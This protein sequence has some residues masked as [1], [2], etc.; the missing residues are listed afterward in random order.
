MKR[1]NIYY[2]FSVFSKQKYT[3]YQNEQQTKLNFFLH[4][5]I[6]KRMRAQLHHLYKLALKKGLLC[7]TALKYFILIALQ[8]IYLNF[9]HISNLSLHLHVYLVICFLIHATIFFI[10]FL[11]GCYHLSSPIM[12]WHKLL[13][14]QLPT[15]FIINK[16]QQNTNGAIVPLRNPLS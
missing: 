8:K 15:L 6:V 16:F 2:K 11:Y 7:L 5:E 3:Q 14:S 13:Q 1:L 12:L 9:Q 4:Q 10:I